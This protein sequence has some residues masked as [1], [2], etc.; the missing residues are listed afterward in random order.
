MEDDCPYIE[1][2]YDEMDNEEQ[3]ERRNS[4]DA[5]HEYD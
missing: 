4:F 3:Y 1:I 5:L 2:V